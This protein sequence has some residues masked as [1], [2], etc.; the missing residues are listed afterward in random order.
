MNLFGQTANVWI[1]LQND[2]YEKWLN[3]NPVIYSNWS[4]S[5]ILNVSLQIYFAEIILQRE[6]TQGSFTRHSFTSYI[7]QA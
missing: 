3:G 5:D 2:D 4:P 1:G 7:L 6:P